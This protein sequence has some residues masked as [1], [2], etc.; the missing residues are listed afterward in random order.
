M[1]KILLVASMLTSALSALAGIEVS[2]TLPTAGTPEHSYTM[3][4]AQG[5]Y[6]NA[7]T[8][9]TKTRRTMPNLLSMKA[10]RRILTTFTT[11]LQVSGLVIPH[12]AAT[13]I[14]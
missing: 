9:P 4:N 13:L 12:K 11:L 5:Y 2:Q 6:C 3:A 14:K 10:T 7:T 1:K 8:S